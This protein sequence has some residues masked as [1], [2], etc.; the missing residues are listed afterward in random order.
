MIESRWVFRDDYRA[1]IE[2][3]D[4]ELNQLSRAL[5]PT[6]VGQVGDDVLIHGPSGTGKTS[7]AMTVIRSLRSQSPVP[8]THIECGGLTPTELLEACLSGLGKRLAVSAPAPDDL[9]DSLRDVVGT[10]PYPIVLDEG[11]DLP[12]LDVLEGLLSIDSISVIVICHDRRRWLDAASERVARRFDLDWQIEFQRY[13]VEQLVDILRPRVEAGLAPGV[14]GDEQLEEIADQAAGTPRLA[15]RGLFMAARTGTDAGA[16]RIRDRDVAGCVDRA[17][18]EIRKRNLGKLAPEWQALYELLR[19]R[20]PTL[21]AHELKNAYEGAK[22]EIFAE[23]HR[24]PLSWARARDGLHKIADYRL[25]E[26]EGK[27]VSRR[28][29][30]VEEEL[31]APGNGTE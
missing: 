22:A 19:T 29:S 16:D 6:I 11:G 4:A 1:D 27:T 7:S 28:Y 25:I 13:G 26:I 24:S 10:E 9:L 2:H 3:R 31:A 15:I 30:V 21:R 12:D 23:S 20:G 17:R 18:A 14:V 8:S 5:A